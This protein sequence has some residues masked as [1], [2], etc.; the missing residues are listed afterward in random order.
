[1]HLFNDSHTKVVTRWQLF[2]RY[3]EIVRIM[4]RHGFGYLVVEFGLQ[5]FVPFHKGW[6][7]Y[8]P[9][10]RPYSSAEHLRLLFEE[11]GPTFIKMGQILSTRPD[12]LPPEMAIEF[13]KLQ[14]TAPPVAWKDIHAV[15]REHLSRS[16]ETVFTELDSTPEASASIGQVHRG[17]LAD[18]Q[19]VAVKVQRPGVQQ[20]IAVD[21]EVLRGIARRV[22]Q[23]PQ[24]APYEPAA[25]VEEF[26]QTITR[27][28]DY[29]QEA[30]NIDRYRRDINPRE[31]IRVP[32]V[33]HSLSSRHVLVMEYIKGVRIDDIE[34]LQ[35]L[36][37]DPK[38]L[39]NRLARL[40]LGT[41]FSKGFFHADPHPGNFRITEEG[42]MV[43]LDFGMVGYLSPRDR[44]V[45]TELTMAMVEADPERMTDRLID[46]GLKVKGHNIAL[47]EI[48]MGRFLNNYFD[49]PLSQIPMGEVLTNLLELI[50]SLGMRLPAQM[51]ILT[52]TI[53]MAEGIGTRLDPDFHLVPVARKFVR[54]AIIRRF[55]PDSSE[56]KLRLAS[57]DVLTLAEQAPKEIRHLVGR[58]RRGEMGVDITVNDKQVIR[59]LRQL[60]RTIKV[61]ALTLALVI[62]VALLMLI[63][64]PEG[65]ELW[66]RWIFSTG[67]VAALLL[68]SYLLFSSLRNCSRRG[69]GKDL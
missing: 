27:E 26:A 55:R 51:A 34:Q 53:L 58:L 61:S 12:L 63:Y 15:L 43:L 69:E 16:P 46:L 13:T 6:L 7:G 62:A 4:L 44:A 24:F 21:L 11:L 2:R 42:T 39:A 30:R 64:H 35:K 47:L 37:V 40:L 17:I 9:K 48:E 56:S 38:E 1:M 20:Q 49:L 66:I 54:R 50:R 5:R 14:D 29:R 31:S 28:L 8:S 22:A 52:K 19:V 3:R 32:M 68:L 67:L 45:L 10:E 57:L 60:G 33:F 23:N 65:W 18:G 41:A 36:N 59:E 25:I